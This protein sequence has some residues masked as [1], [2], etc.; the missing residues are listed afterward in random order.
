[1]WSWRLAAT[2]YVSLPLIWDIFAHNPPKL[3]K[4]NS[5]IFEFERD[6]FGYKIWRWRLW[7]T[8]FIYAQGLGA[9][10]HLPKLPLTP[11]I[12]SRNYGSFLTWP[13]GLSKTHWMQR[14]LR[15]KMWITFLYPCQWIKTSTTA[16]P[17]C[18]RWQ[19]C[20]ILRKTWRFQNVESHVIILHQIIIITNNNQQNNVT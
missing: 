7:S 8:F 12:P 4:R 14:I 20:R 18:T 1:M 13:L 17:N 2:S 5:H 16:N 6:L 11:Q 3:A 19:I 9:F 10:T 15:W